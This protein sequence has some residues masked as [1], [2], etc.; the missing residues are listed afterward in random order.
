MSLTIRFA[1]N[2]ASNLLK[3]VG[4]DTAML[5][6]QL[7]LGR[8]TSQDRISIQL[9]GN[10]YLSEQQVRDFFVM[11]RRRLSYEPMAYILGEK[12]FY[13]ARFVVDQNCLIPRPDTEVVV[14]ECLKL[15]DDGQKTVFDI[16]TGSGAIAIALLL[17]RPKI[18]VEACDISEKALE[19]AS[20]NAKNLRVEDRLKLYYGDLFKPFSTKADLIVS[21]PPY[22]PVSHGQ[23]LSATVREYEPKIAL[24]GGEDGLDFYRAI[25]KEAPNYLN[26]FGFLVMEMGFDQASALEAIVKN[27][28]R[29]RFFKDLAGHFRGIVLQKH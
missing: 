23:D 4:I 18:R 17:N 20:I 13:G 10:N 11:L 14:E 9:F 6:A 27:D 28:W 26:N 19:I 21:N 2:L 24:F 3:E 29:Y 25:I 15:L 12:E 16:C 22:I 5:D 7:I 8:I 1:Q